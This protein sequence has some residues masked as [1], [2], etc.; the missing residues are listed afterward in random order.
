MTKKYCFVSVLIFILA[1]FCHISAFTPDCTAY[2]AIK[3]DI[4]LSLSA[5]KALTTLDG[6]CYVADTIEED[7]SVYTIVHRISSDGTESF[8]V[9]KSIEGESKDI[10]VYSDGK[11]FLLMQTDR[12]VIRSVDDSTDMTIKATGVFDIV[13]SGDYLFYEVKDGNR[14]TSYVVSFGE[15]LKNPDV[16]FKSLSHGNTKIAFLGVDPKTEGQAIAYY[17]TTDEKNVAKTAQ[18]ALSV[19][20]SYN[21]TPDLPFA[22]D[23]KTIGTFNY[24]GS[25]CFYSAEKIDCL[26]YDDASVD[27]RSEC[28]IPMSEVAVSADKQSGAYT[29]FVLCNYADDFENT[30]PYHN[31]P[32]LLY[33]EISNNGEKPDADAFY[34]A[35]NAAKQNG[36][37]LGA[38]ELNLAV[39]QYDIDD[40][41]IGSVRGYPS[42][43]IYT[44]VTVD[45]DYA[46]KTVEKLTAADRFIVLSTVE[47][48]GK[49]YHFIMLDGKFGWI[50]HS[51]CVDFFPLTFSGFDC[52]TLNLGVRVYD[53]PYQDDAFLKTRDDSTVTL[54]KNRQLTVIGKYKEFYLVTYK[55]DDY[56]VCGFVLSSNI[57]QKTE[58]AVYTSYLRKAANPQAGK[59][60]SVYKD[61]RLDNIDDNQLRDAD[62]SVIKVKA[63]KEVRLYEV[64][65]DGTCLV[66]VLVN[67]VLYKGYIESEQLL[68]EYNVGLTNSQLLATACISIVL[69]IIIYVII[70]RVRKKRMYVVQEEA[71]STLNARKKTKGQGKN[72]DNDTE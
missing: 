66:G 67:D 13:L 41:Q 5:P 1:L 15:F 32:R 3:N 54:E 64:F 45:S 71:E 33:F 44:A 9:D 40:L 60:L 57:G 52:V 4:S 35:V 59:T 46:I 61:A 22:I 55:Q 56:S 68:K 27:M 25:A 2:A 11:T 29:F 31:K 21:I 69:V 30:N 18:M 7:G 42:N 16:P 53:L 28:N 36:R 8:F 38:S 6:D 34:S 48:D 39:P 65:D 62:G 58:E 14:Y 24:G 47:K 23:E 70:L 72:N 17:Q 12:I 26:L 63:G 37:L 19:D 49:S 50:Q 20:G 51:D 10:E 43:I